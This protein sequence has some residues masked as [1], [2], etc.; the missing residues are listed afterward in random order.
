VNLKESLSI[1]IITKMYFWNKSHTMQHLLGVFITTEVRNCHQIICTMR[2]E[3]C[4]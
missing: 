2:A 4:K 1:L 3:Y